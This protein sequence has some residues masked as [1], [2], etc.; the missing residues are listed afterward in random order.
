MS[1]FILCSLNSQSN[2]RGVSMSE[3]KT[4]T[5]KESSNDLLALLKQAEK[6]APE[7][8]MIV[9]PLSVEEVT[10]EANAT[11]I[12]EVRV[13]YHDTRV[14]FRQEQKPGGQKVPCRPLY[15]S[16]DLAIF[17]SRV[18]ETVGMP[19]KGT[20]IY[21]V[22]YDVATT[23][24]GEII[25]ED[26]PN[27][28]FGQEGHEDEPETIKVPKLL[29]RH[30]ETDEPLPPKRLMTFRP[31]WG[32]DISKESYTQLK[33][34]DML[35]L[36]PNKGVPRKNAKV[37]DETDDTSIETPDAET[38]RRQAK[39]VDWNFIR[40]LQPEIEKPI[41]HAW[42]WANDPDFQDNEEL[43][44]MV[45]EMQVFIENIPVAPNPPSKR[46]ERE[47]PGFNTPVAS[48]AATMPA[49]TFAKPPEEVQGE[50][51]E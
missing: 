24:N 50:R 15:I 47:R 41:L 13:P 45:R 1:C 25:T 20:S 6:K 27:P 35:N 14:M 19:V 8:K 34:K 48:A 17:V 49:D 33:D 22:G 46:G 3:T 18:H 23:G 32:K 9:S 21:I 30:P 5:I 38:G 40:G 11:T 2:L 10:Q 37:I 42:R 12:A 31:Q 29:D 43:Q 39:N 36:V 26:V 16:Y 28:L 4:Q 44:A 7:E 51:D